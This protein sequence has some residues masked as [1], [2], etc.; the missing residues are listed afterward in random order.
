[1]KPPAQNDRQALVA[2]CASVSR[3]GVEAGSLLSLADRL[4]RADGSLAQARELREAVGSRLTRVPPALRRAA[5]VSLFLPWLGVRLARS[6]LRREL[7]VAGASVPVFA[8]S[9]APADLAGARVAVLVT[10]SADYALA[11]RAAADFLAVGAR[12]DVILV[13]PAAT[14]AEL[15][16][17][18]RA[19]CGEMPNRVASSLADAAEFITEAEPPYARVSFHALDQTEV[20]WM[21]RH[22]RAPVLDINLRPSVVDAAP[23]GPEQPIP[24]TWDLSALERA[25]AERERPR[26]AIGPSGE[27]VI[28]RWLRTPPEQGRSFLRLAADVDM[29]EAHRAL[30]CLVAMRHVWIVSVDPSLDPYLIERVATDAAF[31]EVQTEDVLAEFL[32]PGDRLRVVGSVGPELARAAGRSTLFTGPVTTDPWAELAPYYLPQT[33]RLAQ[34]GLLRPSALADT[35]CAPPPRPAH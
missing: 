11:A 35:A 22:A 29:T 27:T 20:V 4:C 25:V 10:A 1:M 28:R 16:D 21:L 24:G 34:R 6:A 19:S 17:C 26:S 30:D 31:C 3:E 33:V 12:T 2:A 18:L 23:P 8:P 5:A 15:A 7:A 14:D 32:Q 9:A 13:G